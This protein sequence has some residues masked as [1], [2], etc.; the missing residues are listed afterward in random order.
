MASILDFLL[1]A[2]ASTLFVA[3]IYHWVVAGCWR[4]HHGGPQQ[5]PTMTS[6]QGETPDSAEN[7]MVELI[8]THKHQKGMGLAGED[9]KCAV[10]LF[11]STVF[12]VNICYWIAAG[13]CH[14]GHGG[15][16]GGGGPQQRP[17]MATGQGETLGSVENW[18]VELIPIHKHQ[19]GMGLAGED[20]SWCAVCLSLVAEIYYLLWWKK[21][22]SN[23]EIEEDC[24]S[25]TRQFFYMFC[26]KKP[27]SS[28]SS[29]ALEPQQLC[30]SVTITDTHVHEPK[31]QL[32]IKSFGDDG[33]ET[34]ELMRLQ[35]L[36]GPPRFLFT[37][38]EET[39]EDLESEDGKSRGDKS[40]KGS[41]GRSLSDLLLTVETPFLTPLDSPSY[42]TPPLTP[43]D[44]SLSSHT[45]HGFNHQF[46]SSADAEFNRIR[47]S[48][49]PKLE[50]LRDAEDKL[51]GRSKP[52]EEADQKDVHKS[53]G[54]VQED[55]EVK[56]PST[57]MFLK[58]EE[59]GSFITLIVAKN[60][61]RE[62]NH[63]H[64]LPLAS[65]TSIFRQPAN[66][67]TIFH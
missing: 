33:A 46:E 27:S 11:A 67:K 6:G 4:R 8:P 60:K 40:G 22:I 50:F 20:A 56:A 25:P 49:P 55:E 59:N 42:F 13:C 54:A 14:Q 18:M 63:H 53:N 66:K 45:Q 5:Q 1:I 34:A 16:G 58:D 47:S 51:H 21:R 26:W 61:E 19:K 39:K 12:V 62:L 15:D 35:T 43:M 17:T 9:G 7:W 52:M 44:S 65:S 23:R 31:P 2:A 10:C 24:S 29:K 36:S 57:S 41:R 38:K 3:I 30:S 37:I 48:P 28:S 32:H 64:H